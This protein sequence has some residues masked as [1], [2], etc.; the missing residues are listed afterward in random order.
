MPA[1]NRKEIVGLVFGQLTVL[2]V[3]YSNPKIPMC[4]CL[5]ACGNKT[6]IRRHNLGRSANSC[7]C[8][9]REM[10]KK[11]IVKLY[12]SK[13]EDGAIRKLFSTYKHGAKERGYT[14]EISLDVFKNLTE[15][16]CI[17]CGMEPSL[18]QKT[19]RD[20]RSIK[21]NGIDRLDN[22]IGYI[23]SNCVTCCNTCNLAKRA[24]SVE[25]FKIWI[26]RVYHHVCCNNLSHQQCAKAS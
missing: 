21:Y 8:I 14:F 24:M 16:N 6:I 9:K 5:C 15:K 10:S 23:E 13:L 19:E 12:P 25:Q 1:H 22:S 7:G 18:I 4:T 26:E 11:S 2:E 3:D 20:E 17:Y